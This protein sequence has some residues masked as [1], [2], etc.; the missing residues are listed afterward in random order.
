MIKR[1][2]D[3]SIAVKVFGLILVP[4]VL[5]L[6]G[7]FLYLLPLVEDHLLQS[8]K[9]ALKHIVHSVHS[10]IGEYHYRVQSGELSELEAQERAQKRIKH[11]RFARNDYIW[12]NDTGLPY[13]RMVM[14]PAIPELEGKVLDDPSFNRA[15]RAQYGDM[16]SVEV[17]VRG[18]KNL[19]QAFV[20][21]AMRD[22]E[23]YVSYDWPK[24]ILE[25]AT[26]ELYPK[27][28]YVRLF[29]PW[30][31]VVGTGLY[32]D[33]IAAQ[34]RGVR[35]SVLSASLLGMGLVLAMALFFSVSISRPLA[36]LV[37][38]ANRV[39]EGDLDASVSGTFRGE[40]K[41][42][43]RA[44]TRM[45]SAL[46]ASL[47]QA[48]GNG[49]EAQMRAEEAAAVS[50]R[51]SVILRSIGDG[52]IAADTEGKVLVLNRVAEA[53]TGWSREEALGKPF[54]QV[55][56]AV[57]EHSEPIPDIV[58]TVLQS[59]TIFRLDDKVR[60]ISRDGTKRLIADSAAPIRDKNS[61]IIGVVLAFRDET[62]KQRLREEALKSEKLES[63]GILAGG[64]AHDFNNVLTAILGNITSARLNL[65]MP[66]KAERRL[67]E[68]ETATY[69]AR[70]LT[71]QL[72]TFA[73]GG[74]PIRE[75]VA[76]GK[77]SQETAD[78]ALN[79]TDV[80]C[81]YSFPEDLWPV[82]VDPGQI[83]QVIHNL[84]INAHHAMPHGGVITITL[85][86]VMN[87]EIPGVS[88]QSGPYV[89]L[90]MADQ[91]QGI[92]R[93]H[94]S[95]IFDPYF[96]TKPQGSGLGLTTSY[97][98][99][100][101][102][103]GYIEAFSLPGQGASF[104][105]FLP[106]SPGLEFEQE[107][108]NEEASLPD[109]VR[110]KILV[111]DDEQMI[112]DIAS[113]LLEHLGFYPVTVKNGEEALERYQR[114]MLDGSPFDAVIM[115]LTIPNGM[116]GKE[117]VQEILE[118][119][120]KAR[121]VVSSGYSMDPVMADYKSYGFSGVLVKPYRIERLRELLHGLVGEPS[122]TDASR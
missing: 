69:R 94:L 115:D 49:L 35:I 7:I 26:E 83:A 14:H 44:I 80:R 30:G 51:L 54:A 84:V 63:L 105:I 8:R 66:D 22:G 67:A 20:E 108:Q 55:F 82:I 39:S 93:E 97:S 13:P 77:L 88:S 100:K 101:N 111:M 114:A 119:D 31:W 117:A 21:V 75:P 33:D 61:Q 65:S 32:V 71:Q 112:L 53:L 91:G 46:K 122:G 11:M 28:S 17:F 60:L 109:N 50:E 57:D 92:A 9:E 41:Y 118:I 73:R 18:S 99:I 25:G 120:P 70:H 52:V 96:S 113:D 23:G 47:A 29:E 81:R 48:E 106:A 98:I 104:H 6:A 72:L 56:Q 121:V 24:P 1:V 10:L 27:E 36:T 102:H 45:V 34:M 90:V 79:G 116:G 76:L 107:R 110:A 40:T 68:A 42:L 2:L 5:F 95:K 3:A 38:Y 103:G 15:M 59:N 12:I 64:I 85:A 37:V 16:G 4:G 19:F 87:P 86:N 62:E 74:A 58:E 43:M 89:H 78:F